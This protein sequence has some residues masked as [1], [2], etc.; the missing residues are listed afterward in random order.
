MVGRSGARPPWCELAGSIRAQSPLPLHWLLRSR[1]TGRISISVL[2]HEFFPRHDAPTPLR[3]RAIIDASPVQSSAASTT[4]KRGIVAFNESAGRLR[5]DLAGV[6]EHRLRK[7]ACALLPRGNRA[8]RGARA[9][10]PGPARGRESETV[11]AAVL[12][13]RDESHCWRSPHEPR[14]RA[15]KKEE[16]GKSLL[17]DPATSGRSSLNPSKTGPGPQR[18]QSIAPR[19]RSTTTPAATPGGTSRRF[20]L[21]YATPLWERPP[22]RQRIV[23]NHLYWVAYY[24]QII[25]AEIATILLNQTSAA[26]LSSTRTSAPSATCSTWRRRRSAPH[27]RLQKVGR[28]SKLDLFARASSRIRCARCT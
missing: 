5:E 18:G 3:E 19:S 28:P 12:R 7:R 20:S 17:D 6:G 2:L 4:R 16:T 27:R 1:G 22:S 25:S 8:M 11:R 23:L 14:S 24:A 26:G 15:E 21:L 10:L 9:G 13:A